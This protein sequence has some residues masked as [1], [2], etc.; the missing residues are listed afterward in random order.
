M[1]KKIAIPM[2]KGVLCAHFGHCEYFAIVTVEN[3]LVV[4][5]Q[6]EV[7]PAHEPGLYPKWIASFGVTDVIAGGMGQK[8]ID[9]FNGQNINVFVGSPIE[10]ADKIVEAFLAGTLSLNANYCDHDTRPKHDCKSEHNCG[11]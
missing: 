7:P 3:D 6:E 4:K 8:A 2:E 1:N 10:A 5:S 9:L 11:Q